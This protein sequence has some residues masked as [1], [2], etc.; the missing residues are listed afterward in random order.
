MSGMDMGGMDMSAGS[1]DMGNGIPSLFYLQKV[2]W[3]A[4][5]AVIAA[6]FLVN[7][8]NKFLCWQR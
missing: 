4:V 5:G 8:Y 2:Y 7:A 1:M 3:A 6:F